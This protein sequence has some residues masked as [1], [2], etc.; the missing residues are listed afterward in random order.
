[1]SEKCVLFLLDAPNIDGVLGRII[2]RPPKQED[3]PDWKLLYEWLA[4]GPRAY[5]GEF[6]EACIF[7]NLS[8]TSSALRWVEYLFKDIGY[9]VFTK[10]KLN[11]EGDIDDDIIQHFQARVQEGDVTEIILASHD[12]SAFHGPL[13]ELKKQHPNLTITILCFEEKSSL[14]VNEPQFEHIDLEDVAVNG[15][16]LFSYSLP[17]FVLSRIPPEG[18]WYRPIHTQID[19][20]T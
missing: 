5:R 12:G 7:L 2:G 14:L 11:G 20:S 8:P 16:T 17:R 19:T 10:P 1:M 9:N 3:R 6:L 18:R 13:L 15:K 4:T